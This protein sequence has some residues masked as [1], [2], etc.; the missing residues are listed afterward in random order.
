[1]CPC[2]FCLWQIIL[3][4]H[5]LIILLHIWALMTNSSAPDPCC[6]DWEGRP[7]DGELGWRPHQVRRPHT[8]GGV[9]PAQCRG[10][11]HNAL[12]LCDPVS[13][14]LTSDLKVTWIA[15]TIRQGDL[16]LWPEA[17]P[18]T[19]NY[20]SRGSSWP[21]TWRWPSYHELYVK[22]ILT[23]DLKV[24]RLA[25]TIKMWPEGGWCQ[26]LARTLNHK[27]PFIILLCRSIFIHSFIHSLTY[28][29]YTSC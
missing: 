27:S 22:V 7:H 24:T 21:L 26:H 23:S 6:P 20:M 4:K 18:V 15:G 2:L 19:M 11:T 9:L 28:M 14:T 5:A 3:W 12:I 8:V 10:S 13:V 25:Q 29:E 1:M 17:D 16:D